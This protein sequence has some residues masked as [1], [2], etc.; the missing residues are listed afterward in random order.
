MSETAA[1]TRSYRYR[2]VATELRARAARE[3]ALTEYMRRFYGLLADELDR[4][5]D[6][7]DR[8]LSRRA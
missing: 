7:A 6:E 2:M 5:A 1:P 4:L 3:H 8:Q